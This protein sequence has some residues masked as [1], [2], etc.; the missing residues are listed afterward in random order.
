[1]ENNKDTQEMPEFETPAEL[2]N[3]C[4]TK[5][6]EEA[7]EEILKSIQSLNNNKKCKKNIFLFITLISLICLLPSV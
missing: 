3:Y 2:A 7:K 5:A 6:R 4:I 1:M